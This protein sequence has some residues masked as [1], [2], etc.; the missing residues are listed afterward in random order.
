MGAAAK[1]IVRTVLESA[2]YTVYPFGYESTFSTMKHRLNDRRFEGDV[3][4][5]IRSMPDFLVADDEERP[6]FVEVKFRGQGERVGLKNFEIWRYKQ[7][8]PETVLVLLSPFGDRFFAQHVKS[9]K[10]IGD[11]YQETWFE[12]T[13]FAAISS[14]FPRTKGKLEPFLVGIDKLARLWKEEVK[15]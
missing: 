14:V 9:L 4:H 13:D 6:Q 7:Y 15:E 12:Y 5:R 8:W 10:L 1:E 11:T 2:G 3:A